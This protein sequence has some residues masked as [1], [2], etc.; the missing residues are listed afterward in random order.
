MNHRNHNL[1]ISDDKINLKIQTSQYINVV[2]NEIYQKF[3]TIAHKKNLK[4]LEIGSS[5]IN[6]A[7][8]Y[9]KNIEI[10]SFGDEKGTY[11]EN[12]KYTNASFDLIIAKDVLHHVKDIKKAFSEF[13]R[14]LKE[15]GKV[16]VSEPSWSLLGRLIFKYFHP[17]PWYKS[18]TFILNSKDPW[19]S[20]QRL[21]KNIIELEDDKQKELLENFQLKVY[22]GTYGISYLLSGGIRKQGWINEKILIS[23]HKNRN[24]VPKFVLRLTELNR[25]IEF[26]RIA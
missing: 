18:K 17:E 19:D 4:V 8:Q 9:F 14:V 11:A 26:Q 3:S 20:N 2:Y 5:G 22:P 24:K 15:N 6:L 10:T 16:I 25:I 7:Y 12:L 13:N 23:I 21:I 1:S